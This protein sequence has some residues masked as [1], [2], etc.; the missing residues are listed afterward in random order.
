[1]EISVTGAGEIAALARRLRDAGR[2]DLRL[3]LSRAIR[4]AGKPVAEGA[5]RD[6]LALPAHGPKHTA[7]RKRVARTVKLSVRT[8]GASVGVRI[9]AGTRGTD[10]GTLA[11][12]MNRGTWRHPVYGNRNAWVTQSVPPGWFDRPTHQ[13][14]PE[15]RRQIGEA[16]ARI[17]S[18]IEG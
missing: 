12:Y 1:M 2:G 10:V 6:V 16:M 11:R 15:A 13:A 18:Q 7:L 5:R 14:A 8:G 17:R 9:T 3:E 4:A